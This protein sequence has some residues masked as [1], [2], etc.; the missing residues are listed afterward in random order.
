MWNRALR[1]ALGYLSEEDDDLRSQSCW[2]QCLMM[3]LMVALVTNGMVVNGCVAGVLILPARISVSRP[4]VEVEG[5]EH[6]PNI[7]TQA[8]Y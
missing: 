7:S 6:H 3:T 4:L 5:I 1:H 2:Q 8:L